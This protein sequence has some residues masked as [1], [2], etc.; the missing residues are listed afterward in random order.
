MFDHLIGWVF[1]FMRRVGPERPG[2]SPAEIT[3]TNLLPGVG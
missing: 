1:G 2:R 3:F